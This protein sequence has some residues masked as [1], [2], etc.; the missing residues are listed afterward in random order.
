M[1]SPTLVARWRG[2]RRWVRVLIIAL[3]IAFTIGPM[4]ACTG[5]PGCVQVADEHPTRCVDP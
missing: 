2:L 1:T 5:D 4:V 3:S